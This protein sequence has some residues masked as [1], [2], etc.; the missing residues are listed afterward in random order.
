MSYADEIARSVAN[1]KKFDVSSNNA[2]SLLNALDPTSVG[3]GIRAMGDGVK[4]IGTTFEDSATD[5]V[6][7]QLA[8]RSRQD[9]TGAGV[10][11]LM[12][13]A[14]AAKQNVDPLY[15]DKTADRSGGFNNDLSGMINLKSLETE[16]ERLRTGRESEADNLRKAAAE[17]QLRSLDLLKQK[18]LTANIKQVEAT[19]DKTKIEIIREKTAAALDPAR[20][21]ANIN[22]TEIDIDQIRN[23]MKWTDA[24]K[25]LKIT[26]LQNALDEDERKLGNI[27]LESDQLQANAADFNANGKSSGLADL[28]LKLID[29]YNNNVAQPRLIA[30]F[31]QQMATT[32]DAAKVVTSSELAALG[33][34]RTPAARKR[35][36]SQILTRLKNEYDA[37]IPGIMDT[38]TLSKQADLIIDSN[39]ELAKEFKVENEYYSRNVTADQKEFVQ[40]Q[41]RGIEA[42]LSSM[43]DEG[44]TGSERATWLKKAIKE[45]NNLKGKKGERLVDPGATQAWLK[46]YNDEDLAATGMKAGAFGINPGDWKLN[47]LPLRMAGTDPKKRIPSYANFTSYENKVLNAL[48]SKYGNTTPIERTNKLSE[49]L[50]TISGYSVAKKQATLFRLSQDG[51]NKTRMDGQKNREVNFQAFRN[52]GDDKGMVS[53]VMN[54]LR[55][56]L[57]KEQFEDLTTDGRNSLLDNVQNFWANAKDEFAPQLIENDVPNLNNRAE[58]ARAMFQLF[59]V[60]NV[61]NTDFAG[62]NELVA[63]EGTPTV[64]S[65]LGFEILT[66]LGDLTGNELRETI[67]GLLPKNMVPNMRKVE[68]RKDAL[69]P[70]GHTPQYEGIVKPRPQNQ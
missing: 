28:K 8:A 31:K 36:K 35:L 26:K 69:L 40:T 17:K 9:P 38:A 48:R 5:Q 22:K 68:N 23:N 47:D 14:A 15:L 64:N 12:A 37:V 39:S 30:K 27:N 61:R 7:A 16:R 32:V 45:Y 51:I 42:T 13:E 34:D 66:T 10:D 41:K 56:E 44:K 6:M 20:L 1:I 65:Y 62:D 3:D 19:T 25:E 70:W 24:E 11:A 18:E 52:A 57:P 2:A 53:H 54:R 4:G 49:I 55:T 29:N 58:L 43:A 21:K 60:S 63:G 59:S 67:A 50:S 33:K 46:K